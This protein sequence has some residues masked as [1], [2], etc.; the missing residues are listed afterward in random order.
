MDLSLVSTM[1]E[2][3]DLE[4]KDLVE[5]RPGP[6]VEC[7]FLEND[8]AARR[9]VCANGAHF[10]STCRVYVFNE[11]GRRVLAVETLAEDSCLM[12]HLRSLLSEVTAEAA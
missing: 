12:E 2:V 6:G 4:W 10:I 7:Y 9:F 5:G 8:I 1:A 3:L 11:G